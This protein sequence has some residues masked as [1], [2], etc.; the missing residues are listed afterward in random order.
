MERSIVV[1]FRMPPAGVE[2]GPEGA[3]LSRARSLCARGEALGGQLVAWGAAVLAIAWDEDSMEE[4]VL[5]ATS[6][7]EEALSASRAWACGIAEGELEEFSPDGARMQLA[8][9]R[10]LLVA[11]SLAKVASPGDVL[12]D[13]DVRAVRAGQLTLVGPRAATDAGERVRGWKLDLEHPWRRVEVESTERIV[14]RPVAPP[15]VTATQEMPALVFDNGELSTSDVLQIVEAAGDVPGSSDRR[16]ASP[17]AD[18]MRR[19]AGGHDPVDAAHVLSELRKVR[20]AAEDGSVRARCQ[21]ALALAM[22]LAL[23]GRA[24]EALLEALDALA[25][26]REGED[27]KAVGACLALLAKLYAGTGRTGEASALRE[28]AGV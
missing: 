9:G 1:A 19:L 17:L 2:P 7:R 23:A 26:A 8:W 10:A 22:A 21:A 5:L 6:V 24:E 18:R 4:A 14:L 3:Y 16:R 27:A 12:V 13:G 25:R 15:D 28:T 11:T 20:A